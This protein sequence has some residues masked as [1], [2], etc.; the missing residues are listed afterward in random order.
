MVASTMSRYLALAF[1]VV[2]SQSVHAHQTF[3]D[4][5]DNENHNMLRRQEPLGTEVYDFGEYNMQRREL[6]WGFSSLLCEWA[7]P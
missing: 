2:A 5:A 6:S 4:V 3:S 1:L 7:I